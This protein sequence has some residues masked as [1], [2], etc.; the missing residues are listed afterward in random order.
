M[1]FGIR[2]ADHN[3]CSSIGPT[4]L[5]ISLG[6]GEIVVS[7][8]DPNHYKFTGKE[9]DAESGLDLENT[10]GAGE[11]NWL[12]NPNLN[13][14]GDVGAALQNTFNRLGEVDTT[15]PSPGAWPTLHR[16]VTRPWLPHPP[17]LSEGGH[18]DS[19][20]ARV[21]ASE[22]MKA[23]LSKKRGCPSIIAF[24]AFEWGQNAVPA[25]ESRNPNRIRKGTAESGGPKT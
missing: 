3:N 9:R 18:S 13:F 7:G 21:N 11:P 1:L 24:F 2:Y 8:S 15:P 23:T 17:R 14:S 12:R 10:T 19:A 4:L 25:P 16:A 20:V 5:A 22:P 6:S